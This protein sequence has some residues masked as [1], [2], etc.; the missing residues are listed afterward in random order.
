MAY[1]T[2]DLVNVIAELRKRLEELYGSRFH[3]LLLYGSYARG[4]ADEGSDVDLLVLLDGPV[5]TGLEIKRTSNISAPLSLA[6]DILLALM[7]VDYEAY[8]KGKTSFLRI[9]RKDATRAA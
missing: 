5:D 1:L 3:D 9:V 8:Q 7:P 4:E 6:H 2:R